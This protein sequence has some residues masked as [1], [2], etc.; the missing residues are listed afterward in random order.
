MH[1]PNPYEVPSLVANGAIDSI[2]DLLP[3]FGKLRTAVLVGVVVATL[4]AM[5]LLISTLVGAYHYAQCVTVPLE[6]TVD[7]TRY[8]NIVLI[9]TIRCAI[10]SIGFSYLSYT[11]GRYYRCLHQHVTGQSH[12]LA[13]LASRQLNCWWCGCTL[14]IMSIVLG[15]LN[16]VLNLLI[17]MPVSSGN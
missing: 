1:D 13:L 3:W 2:A 16:A 14:A 10:Q 8:A 7:E 9:G 17:T 4:F 5:F 6:L 12:D 11:L 15:L